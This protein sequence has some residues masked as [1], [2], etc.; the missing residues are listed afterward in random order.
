MRSKL[1]RLCLVPV[2]ALVLYLATPPAVTEAACFCYTRQDC[3]TCYPVLAGEPV[4][5]INH[6]CVWL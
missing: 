3:W 2:L 1:W 6:G 5:C 4:S